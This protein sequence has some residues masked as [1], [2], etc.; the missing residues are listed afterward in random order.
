M[1]AFDFEYFRPATFEEAV[2]KYTAV[3]L[4]NGRAV[5]FSGGTEFI[6]FA[7]KGR[8]ETDVVIDL[9]AVP[10]CH[11]FEWNEDELIIGS[12]VTLNTITESNLFPLLGEVVKK[13]ADHTSRN[14]ITIGGNIN[15][16]LMY[17][18]SLLGL[19]IVEAEVEVIGE[20]ERKRVALTDFK[21]N[22]GEFVSQIYIPCKN[23]QL[24]FVSLKRTKLSKVGYP[25]VSIASVIK[26]NAI[27]IAFS[28]L[29]AQP[30]RCQEV[31]KVLNDDSLP[32]E[33]RIEKAIEKIPM[34]IVEDLNASK[35]YRKFVTAQLIR[36]MFQA[37][38]EEK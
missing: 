17:K 34:P 11:Q 37:F 33:T 4:S 20:N 2:E 3:K 24:P 13:I 14:K 27:R 7:R 28:G 38:E 19:L 18:E 12:A 32:V 35:D 25:V 22:E 31:E 16:H 5:Y 8:I 1:I 29:T 9:K 6:T 26:D 10:E 23:L 36:E 30:F 15:S 21:L